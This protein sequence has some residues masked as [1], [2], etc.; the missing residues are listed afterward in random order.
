MARFGDGYRT[1]SAVDP[2]GSDL[3]VQCERVVCDGC[4]SSLQSLISNTA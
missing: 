4:V 3:E 1:L 2:M